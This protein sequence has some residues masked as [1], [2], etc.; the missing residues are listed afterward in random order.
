MLNVSVRR[1]VD[2]GAHVLGSGRQAVCRRGCFGV[3][4]D[5]LL[6]EDSGRDPDDDLRLQFEAM[7]QLT[8]E[9]KYA[10]RAVLKGLLLKHATHR[11]T[12]PSSNT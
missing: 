6:C 7:S 8:P 12:S 5:W 11:F 4:T 3:T 2:S 1:L 10:T 9:E